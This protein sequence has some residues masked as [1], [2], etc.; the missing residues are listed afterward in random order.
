MFSTAEET[1]IPSKS[2]EKYRTSA[3]QHSTEK[4]STDREEQEAADGETRDLLI[5]IGFVL[6]LMDLLPAAA[7]LSIEHFLYRDR[8][9]RPPS[10]KH[11]I[12]GRS[13]EE[14]KAQ[15]PSEQGLEEIHENEELELD[16][17]EFDRVEPSQRAEEEDNTDVS[18]SNGN[19]QV[20]AKPEDSKAEELGPDR[21][22]RRDTE[23]WPAGRSPLQNPRLNGT[24]IRKRRK[25]TAGNQRGSCN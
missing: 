14:D 22:K 8:R 12:R 20:A 11:K 1:T 21:Q 10:R 6:L 2:T 16:L 17:R 19:E 23:K 3:A 18:H 25:S 13:N 7:L 9:P 15:K 24:E 4:P 5:F